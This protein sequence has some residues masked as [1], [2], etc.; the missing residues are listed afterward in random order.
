MLALF[1][2]DVGA[3]LQELKETLVPVERREMRAALKRWS[4]TRCVMLN[5][6]EPREQFAIKSLERA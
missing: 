1:L 2:I 3:F 5:N 4:V 6:L